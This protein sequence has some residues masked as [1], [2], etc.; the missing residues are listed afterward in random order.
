MIC[1]LEISEERNAKTG[2]RVIVDSVLSLKSNGY[3]FGALT[4]FYY[5]DVGCG[6]ML[7]TVLM[8]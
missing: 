3:N 7:R 8:L 4:L 1:R 2:R 5:N 6:M